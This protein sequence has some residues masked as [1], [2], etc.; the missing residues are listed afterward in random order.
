MPWRCIPQRSAEVSPRRLRP[1]SA[2]GQYEAATIYLRQLE[3]RGLS[4]ATIQA[5]TATA[6]GLYAGLGWCRA[7]PGDPFAACRDP[8]ETTLAWE[9]GRGVE[10]C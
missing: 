6:R 5:R 3:R 4:P 7:V 8:R 2:R 9:N 1:G 10:L